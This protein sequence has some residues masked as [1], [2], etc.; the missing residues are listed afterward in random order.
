M[1]TP[2]NAPQKVVGPFP[3]TLFMGCSIQSFNMNLGW[4][5]EPSTCDV[6]L[7]V[8]PTYH[9]S[10]VAYNQVNS[11]IDSKLASQTI[12]N[13]SNAFNDLN[14][15][16]IDQNRNLHRNILKKIDDQLSS[17][18]TNDVN[19]V[20]TKYKDDGKKIW[21]FGNSTPITYTKPDP[22]F[23]AD[24]FGILAGITANSR[25]LDIMGS[26]VHFRF[27]DVIFNGIVKNW[28]Y[29]NGLIDVKLESPT[30]LVKGTKLILKDY[31]GTISTRIADTNFYNNT[32][33][34]V[35]FD[36]ETFDPNNSYINNTI[37]QGNIPNIINIFG[38]AGMANLAYTE[39]RGVSLGLVYDYVVSMLNGGSADRFNPYGAIVG[40]AVRDRSNGNFA[41]WS[42]SVGVPYGSLT[43]DHFN[44]INTTTAIDNINRPLLNFDIVD[45]PRPPNDVYINENH[46]SLLDFIDRCCEPLGYDYYFTL[47]PDSS[48][49][50]KIKVNTIS[51]R[52]QPAINTIKGMVNSFTSDD[53]VINHK[54]GQEFQDTKTRSIILGG[55]QQR[56]FQASTHNLGKYR[57]RR[58]YEPS[59]A[60]FVS[61]NLNASNNSYRVPDTARYRNL[62]GGTYRYKGGAVVAQPG[63]NFNQT[64]NSPHTSQTYL[65][66]SYRAVEQFSN[67][68]SSPYNL[69]QND[70]IKPYFG[71]DLF[72]N[73]RA[74]SFN[75]SLRELFV[76]INVADLAALFP[77]GD[78]PNIYGSVDVSE[79]EI[80]CAMASVDSWLN[81]IFEMPVLGKSIGTSAYI[82]S[83]LSQKYGSNFAGNFFM[84]AL[85][86]FSADKGKLNV[87]PAV[88]TSTPISLENYL[89]YSEA[90]WPILSNLHNFFKS[91]GDTYYGQQFIVRLPNISSYVDSNNI[92]RYS[93]EIADSAWE[94]PGNFIDDTIQIGSSV[95]NG[96]ANEDGTFGAIIGFDNT[97][98]YDSFFS[99]NA[100]TA[101]F[102]PLTIANQ[103]IALTAQKNPNN[104][105][106]PLIHD[107]PRT[108][109]FYMP[110]TQQVATGGA[111]LPPGTTV[112][113]PIYPSDTSAHGY[114]PGNDK[115]YKMYTR[116]TIED[117]YPQA[118]YNKKLTWY[119]GQPHCV[120]KVPSKVMVESPTS[121]LATMMEE[122]L[123]YFGL[124]NNS[125]FAWLLA[126]TL[127]DKGIRIN[128]TQLV[129]P[130]G[131]QQNMPIAYRAAAPVFAAIPLK[132]NVSCYGP[133]VSHPGLGYVNDNNLFNDP[134]P[135]SQ[136]NNLVGEVNFE[137]DEQA[138]PWNYG[139]VSNMDS[140]ILLK[141][142]D[143]NYYQQVLENGTITTAGVFFLNGNLGGT[144]IQ[145]GPIVNGVNVSIGNE[146]FTTTYTM[147][148][149]NR[150]I[151]FFNKQAS[152]NI[153]QVGRESIK[154]RQQITDNIKQMVASTSFGSSVSRTMP[155]GLSY[156]PMGILVGCSYPFLH[157][158]SSIQNV[159]PL[160]R[161]LAFNYNGNINPRLYPIHK[162]KT[163][164]YD[165]QEMADVFT[166]EYHRKS[167][168]SLDGIFSPVSFYPTPGNA[169][170]NI[171]LYNRAN[172]PYCLGQGTLSY[173]VLNTSNIEGSCNNIA[174]KRTSS[175]IA[176]TFC[177]TETDKG[178][179][180]ISKP[181]LADP[182]F[183]LDDGSDGQL[184]NSTPVSVGNPI[185]RFTLNPIVMSQGEFAVTG[186]K[187]NNDNCGHSIDVVAFGEGPPIRGNSL[188]GSTS[189]N[190][191]SNYAANVNQRF[192]AMKGPLVVHGWGY[193]SEGYPVPNGSGE[194][195]Y[196]ESTNSY[197]SVTQKKKADGTWTDPYKINTFYPG[198]AQDPSIWPVGP[199]DLR[200]DSNAG[201]W[202]VGNQYKNVWVTIEIDLAG[203]QPT[204][205][206]I[207]NTEDT[208]ALPEGYRKLVFVRDSIGSFAAP[209]GAD[210]YCSYDPDSGFYIPLYNKAIITSGTLDSTSSATIYQAYKR[211]YSESNPESYTASFRNPLG[212]NINIGSVGLFT[213][214]N[215]SWVL[216]NVK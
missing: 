172:C 104:W 206:V 91:L 10:D 58:V 150:K 20:S 6:K 198:W 121:L 164:L 179:N 26:L 85:N 36:D 93:Y 7:V 186:A 43:L 64:E 141:L 159:T 48:R 130:V 216:Q 180:A 112:I 41:S 123:V 122:L 67:G 133:W 125:S 82:Y 167:M 33:L 98:E 152:E 175:T 185:N 169:T 194:L 113:N 71:Q 53:Y 46:I 207:Y 55:N 94:E 192:F 147:R 78:A 32:N 132:S 107:L 205:G 118:Q 117:V 170:T 13:A 8:D 203:T 184:Q 196:D 212:L 193:D 200:W 188:R 154:L 60:S 176:C 166:S 90:L 126:W 100:A 95:A 153:Q 171:T 35:P 15:S 119:Y 174:G 127:A 69:G 75:N 22:G 135:I 97:A 145:N 21:K 214:I 76:N 183:I 17:R 9:P 138:V 44:I 50:A 19:G 23:L 143:S 79:T 215:G 39:D 52:Y 204:R 2:C 151:G 74:V 178:Q 201:V 140:S 137:H 187:K 34:A 208:T 59:I 144:L 84:N 162:T 195:K 110:Y 4:G 157:G 149:Y 70:I 199:I 1:A 148:T 114:T 66:G 134:N 3:Q 160:P 131:N 61:I 106:W 101:F 24:D 47:E 31:T 124:T 120:I 103:Y 83:Y 63:D 27:D 89:P 105:Y 111:I 109:V 56:L 14:S 29:D 156:S 42:T 128:N 18:V 99:D 49:S 189:S 81:Y 165:E 142:K 57:H 173:S 72:G 96:L 116:A 191:L 5:A 12:N 210:I 161:G 211:N 80:R 87:L 197:V 68:T 139:G 181:S 115:R 30:N 155:K 77:A 65:R 11:F 213:Y 37:F 86:I 209:R 54:F 177:T 182:P 190:I 163:V 28:G 92:R 40:K 51:R 25:N 45:V 102:S 158:N 62:V 168:M 16:T 202:T 136:I 108:D 38:Y 88:V 129:P 146:G 73:N